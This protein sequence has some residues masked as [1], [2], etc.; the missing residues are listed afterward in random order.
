MTIDLFEC[1]K[2]FH[3]N[4]CEDLKPKGPRALEPDM[5]DFRIGFGKEEHDEYITAV[6]ANDLEG[7]LDA[8]VDQVYVALGTAWLQG[9][10]F[11]EAFRRVHAANMSKVRTESAEGSKRFSKYDVVKPA[12]WKAP[13]LTDLVQPVGE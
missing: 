11:N 10:D 3:E 4:F 9:F 13:V 7:Q 5:S 2:E 6:A 1:V 8:L 12:G